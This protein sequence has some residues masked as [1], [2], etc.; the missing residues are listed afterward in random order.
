M[1]TS[2][3][4]PP[5]WPCSRS[6]S[7]RTIAAL[8]D[9]I[10]PFSP[11]FQGE[12]WTA[13]YRLA[14]K[15]DI[16]LW[17]FFGRGLEEPN[18]QSAAHNSIFELINPKRVDG[19]LLLSGTLASHCGLV[20]LRRFL[21]R[22]QGMPLCSLSLPVPN[23]PS[24]V[25][26][27]KQGM[28]AVLDHVIADHGLRRVAFLSG[29][30]QSPEA[31]VRLAEYR[32]ALERYGIGYDAALV[33]CGDFQWVP[34]AIA[35]EEVLRRRPDV[36]AVVAANDH[37]AL[38]AMEVA[39][40]RGRRV[41]D[42]LVV[43]GFD[44]LDLARVSDPP[45]TTV[46][47]PYTATVEHAFDL[48][49]DQIE[50][51]E[52]AACTELPA[53]L[54]TRR[55]CGCMSQ[56]VGNQ[57]WSD[58]N[59][60]ILRRTRW[61]LS[62][63]HAEAGDAEG[64]ASAPSADACPEPAVAEQ[65]HSSPR[66]SAPN[67]RR[68]SET[69]TASSERPLTGLSLPQFTDSCCESYEQ[70]LLISLRAQLHYRIAAGAA[71]SW[72]STLGEGMSLAVNLLSLKQTL[73]TTLPRGGLRTVF[74]SLYAPD[75]FAELEPFV[76]LYDGQPV[77]Q[78]ESRF[79]AHELI[80]PGVYP[81]ECRQILMVFPVV[82]DTHRLGVM[83][84][85]YA[86]DTHPYLMIRDQIAAALKGISQHQAVLQNTM[87]REVQEQERLATAKRLEAVSLLAGG[88]AHDL[89]NVLGPL[90]SLPDVMLKACAGNEAL[91]EDLECIKASA[92][93]A[94]EIAKDLLTLSRQGQT[95][96]EPTD[97]VHIA[98]VCTSGLA[99]QAIRLLNSCVDVAVVLP[100]ESVVI[101][102]SRAHVERAI[103]NL[104]RNAAEAIQGPGNVEVRVA[105]ERVAQPILG[106]ETIEPG[107]YVTIAVSDTGKGIAAHELAHVF[108]PFFS[109]KR[110][111]EN[112][113]S[114]L[115]LSIVHSVVKEHGGFIDVSSTVGVGT[116]ITLYFPFCGETLPVEPS[117]LRL[118]H[119]TGRILL[120][121][122]EPFQLRAGVRVLTH[123]GYQVD[124]LSDAH[125]AL[126]LLDENT[127]DGQSPYD[128]MI[129]DL[130]L[131]SDLDGLQLYEMIRKRYCAQ[132]SSW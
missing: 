27:N 96:K 73:L 51:R 128:L 71:L 99:R 125:E 74:L 126:A 9:Y 29:P 49:V 18:A 97:V 116:T 93:R 131:N 75:N 82:S 19:L 68:A 32:A 59:G 110:L 70:A 92:L 52:V 34:G 47:Q 119:G 112:S 114:G 102:A 121:D 129:L 107:D 106:F 16:H 85:E 62:A 94:A 24:L 132:K 130:L 4:G 124:S 10:A 26:D 120:V 122:D 12:L 69:P 39:R 76:S 90:V 77:Q 91:R 50:G 36:Q 80:P 64:S 54:I 44:D 101:R 72:M 81:A 55:S 60:S 30:P 41:P 28:R 87:T 7:R 23:V 11:G 37:M 113:G 48:I 1:G 65:A 31:Q 20:G 67:E 6:G 56:V 83:V 25:I 13:L 35:I 79:S 108:V 22:Y 127:Q 115:G 66:S 15:R 88:V 33:A 43:T 38:G 8:F 2:W 78:E 89:N 3:S 21:Q 86:G 103:T 98:S 109:Q 17:T 45:L 117:S 40:K 111:A 58:E 95:K 118:C 14:R 42:D 105:R 57:D 84:F 63:R 46:A 61:P 53:E 104:V 123:L 5:S 100:A